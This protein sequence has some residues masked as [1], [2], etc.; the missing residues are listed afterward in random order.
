MSKSIKVSIN[1]NMGESLE[2]GFSRVSFGKYSLFPIPT[3]LNSDF[4]TKLLLNFIDEWKNE[5]IGSNPEREGEIIL[6]FLSV[7]LKQKVKFV[8]S[9]LNDIQMSKENKELIS[10]NSPIKFPEDLADLYDKFKSLPLEI[11]ERHLRAC[12]CYQEALLISN[13]NPTISFF[14]FV[15]C[16]ECLS[17]KEQDFYD[18]LIKKIGDKREISKEEI[19][20]THESYVK[21]YGLNKNFISF[22][23]NH[24]D[25]WKKDFSEKEFKKLL[26]N[27]YSIR[28]SFTHKGE[29]LEK[30]IRYVDNTLKSKSVY[31]KIKDKKVEFP[32]LNY[33]SEIVQKVLI[34]FLGKQNHPEGDNVPELALNEGKIDL[35]VYDNLSFKK[36]GFV[37]TNQIK[38]RK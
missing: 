10:F 9:R 22:I 13:N 31:T 36:G 28:S 6:S 23:V 25:D 38:H 27:I 3:K 37:F 26:S 18:Y 20:R 12:E 29:N 24:Y 19:E 8:S 15:V 17:S 4:K 35:E 32:G 5:Q 33:L 34:N 11:L 14:L 30:Y 16:I 2:P 7:I 1:C 21:E